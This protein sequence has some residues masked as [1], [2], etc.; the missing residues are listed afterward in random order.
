M[1]KKF[2]KHGMMIFILSAGLVISFA[3]IAHASEQ[4]RVI[5]NTICCNNGAI[6]GYSNDC[7]AGGGSCVDHFCGDP[8]STELPTTICP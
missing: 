5:E 6:T 7:T 1:K 3:K 2:I 4:V 8:G